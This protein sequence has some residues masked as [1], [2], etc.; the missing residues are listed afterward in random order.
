MSVG[1]HDD[2]QNAIVDRVQNAAVTDAKSITIAPSERS[3]GWRTGVH[4]EK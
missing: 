1:D 2:Q 4:R 3:R